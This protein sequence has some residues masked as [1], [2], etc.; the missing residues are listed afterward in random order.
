MQSD[1]AGW[2]CRN[3]TPL[4]S[5]PYA[6]VPPAQSLRDHRE[7]PNGRGWFRTSDLPR[8]KRTLSH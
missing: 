5:E 3:V 6:L 8:V 7:L 2:R 1:G 4:E